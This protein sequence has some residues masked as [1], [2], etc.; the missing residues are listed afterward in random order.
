MCLFEKSERASLR[1]CAFY[2]GRLRGRLQRFKPRKHGRRISE[3]PAA[4]GRGAGGGL[5]GVMETLPV[6]ASEHL[7][8]SRWDRVCVSHWPAPA[9]ADTSQGGQPVR[10]GVPLSPFCQP[11]HCALA[12]RQENPGE[13]PWDRAEALGGKERRAPSLSFR[14]CPA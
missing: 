3:K 7:C 10:Q 4:G 1:P 2:P 8:E 14:R 11:P 13:Q 6:V 12:L 5:T 9:S